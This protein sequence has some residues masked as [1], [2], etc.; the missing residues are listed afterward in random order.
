VKKS[1][2]RWWIVAASFL[3]A[4]MLTAMPL[5]DW[6]GHWRPAWVALVLIYWCLAVP[7][8][9]G[10]M[11]GWAMGVLLDVLGGGVLGGNALGL[12]LV[13]F[14]AANYHQRI[15]I[16]PLGQQAIMIGALLW[17]YLALGFAA[18][19]MMGHSP[20]LL[21]TSLPIV[22]SVVLWP[23]LFIILRDLRRWAHLG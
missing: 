9:V 21:D 15:R 5:P 17:F 2:H 1:P 18:R 23:W 8:Q 4:F 14:I 7:E 20:G 10:M 16:V 22:T 19:T 6:A 11:V 12:A 3:V 13:A